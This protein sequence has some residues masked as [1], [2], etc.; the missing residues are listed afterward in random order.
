MNDEQRYQLGNHI[1]KVTIGVNVG[2]SVVK[3][4]AG[5]I[6]RS[7]AMIADGVHSL[8]DVLST[9]AV[10]IGLR[11]AKKPADADHPYGHEK[12]ESVATILLATLLLFTAG[13][14]AY[15]GFMNIIKGST[16]VP[17]RIAVYAALSSIGVKEWM[18]H[19]T[20]KGAKKINSTALQAD[21][22]HH[23][24][25]AFSSIGSLVGIIGARL[26]FSILDPLAALVISVLIGKVAVEIYIQA[27]RQMLDESADEETL[28]K[29]QEHILSI[30]GVLQIDELKTRI[31]ANK[32]Y[33]DVEIAVDQELTICQAHKIA[34]KVHDTIEQKEEKVKHCMVHVNPCETKQTQ[35]T[36][37]GV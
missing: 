29:L 11:M 33:V 8:S 6:G 7:G 35:K 31:H 25:D 37:S 34:E 10:M 26:G 3:L 20:I 27:V 21:A 4:L 36:L 32:V 28:Q 18:Y 19:Y 14:I 22:W 1:S 23:R 30:R 24:S 9:M 17:G 5:V 13:G 16:S 12:M 15:S 2:L